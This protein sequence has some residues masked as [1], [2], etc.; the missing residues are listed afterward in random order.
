M[1]TLWVCAGYFAWRA[2]CGAETG[3]GWR[4][5]QPVPAST[6]SLT[7]EGCSTA[8]AS[9]S[10]DPPRAAE[11]EPAVSAV[12]PPQ[13]LDVTDQGLRRDRGQVDARLTPQRTT[14]PAAPL[15]KEGHAVAAGVEVGAPPRL[16]TRTRAAVQHDRRLAARIPDTFPED[17]VTIAALEDP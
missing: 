6:S 1:I 9:A 14:A 4:D 5:A 17:P 7:C 12:Q 13:R 2:A 3:D 11:H 10:V 8:Y 15:V 16:R